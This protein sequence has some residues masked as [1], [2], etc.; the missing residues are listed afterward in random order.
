MAQN[1]AWPARRQDEAWG[2]GNQVCPQPEGEI[3]NQPPA[4]SELS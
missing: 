3:Q 1:A 2:S 4:L